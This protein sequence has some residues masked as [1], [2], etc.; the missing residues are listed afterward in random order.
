MKEH[1]KLL[2]FMRDT[3]FYKKSQSSEEMKKVFG[4]FIHID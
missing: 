1:K 3:A 4:V 2:E